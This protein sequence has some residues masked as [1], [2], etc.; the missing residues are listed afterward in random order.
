MGKAGAGGSANDLVRK[1]SR[2]KIENKTHLVDVEI[3][4]LGILPLAQLQRVPNL[5]GAG[6]WL[7]ARVWLCAQWLCAKE[8]GREEK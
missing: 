4:R 3:V 2:E 6:V 7:G 5:R 1:R 8:N